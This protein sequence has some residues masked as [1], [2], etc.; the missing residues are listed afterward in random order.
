MHPLELTSDSLQKALDLT[1]RFVRE[2]IDS[3]DSQPSADVFEAEELART[4][5]ESLPSSP[6]S[7]DSILARL[8][9]AIRKSFNTAGPGYLA[10]IP[11]G[12]IMSAALA[13]LIAV[14]T[15]RYRGVRP[16]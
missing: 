14:P 1:T 6:A 7:L 16:P 13:D 10:F 8:R 3:L 5:V 15:N 2:E 9:P 11:G 12:G 4:F